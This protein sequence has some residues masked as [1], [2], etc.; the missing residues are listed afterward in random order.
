MGVDKVFW[1]TLADPPPRARKGPGMDHHSLLQAVPGQG[2]QDKP[3][4]VVYRD[5]ASTVGDTPRAE[6][7]FEDGVLHAQSW[8]I[9]PE[10]LLLQAE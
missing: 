9:T 3:A 10:G 6:L 4:A 7:R 8:Q 1:H 5:L 2:F